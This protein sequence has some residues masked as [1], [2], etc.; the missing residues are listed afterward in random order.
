[1]ATADPVGKVYLFNNTTHELTI[2]LNGA[3][4]SSTVPA[5][6]PSSTE[7]FKFGILAVDRVN[8]PVTD[9][10]KFADKSLLD[11]R[12]SGYSLHFEVV[13]PRRNF[14]LKDNLQMVINKDGYVLADSG[15]LVQYQYQPAV[16]RMEHGKSAG[17]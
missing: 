16:Q 4:L 6:T 17:E 15:D 9:D 11:I 7:A 2:T 3:T 10:P 1:M 12:Y 8:A 5:G 14:P 13:I